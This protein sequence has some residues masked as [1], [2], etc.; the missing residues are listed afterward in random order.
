[1]GE[2]ALPI[3]RDVD[4][5]LAWEGRQEERWEFVGGVPTMKAG[6]TENHDL[7][8][9]NAALALGNRLAG[10]PC[11]V[12]GSNLKVRS[13]VGASMYPD[14]FVRCGPGRADRTVV[15][16]P[17]VVVEVLSPRTRQADLTRKRWAYQAIPS[18][19]A[20]LFIA[21]DEP[22]LELAVREP[23]GSWRSRFYT[24]LEAVVPLAA[25]DIELPMVELYAGADLPGGDA[26]PDSGER[27]G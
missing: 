1:M 10:T 24:G 23:D 25:L 3:F 19:Q 15:D 17:V 2:P 26:E 20:I 11:R 14:A 13:A 18:M 4:E 12:H 16:D 27:D 7:V 21:A 6:G 5:F 22:R 9:M 8:G